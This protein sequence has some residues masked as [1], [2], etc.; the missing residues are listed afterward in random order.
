MTEED[1]ANLHTKFMEM[2]QHVRQSKSSKRVKG[3]APG[4]KVGRRKSIM[5]GLKKPK[6]EATDLEAE[7]TI[8]EDRELDFDAFSQLIKNELPQW[9]AGADEDAVHQLFAA[10]DDDGNGS[11]S[12]SEFINGLAV[13]TG[14]AS[15]GTQTQPTTLV[16]LHELVS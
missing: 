13:F 11:I 1:V 9:A 8:Y 7:A 2:E 5:G 16:V 14:G 3:P 15:P 12:V 6:F 4:G 10:F